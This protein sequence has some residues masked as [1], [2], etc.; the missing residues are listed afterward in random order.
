MIKKLN[1]MDAYPTA[2]LKYVIDSEWDILQALWTLMKKLTVPSN[3][4]IS[5]TIWN[6]PKEITKEPKHNI[7]DN[8]STTTWVSS[9]SDTITSG[10]TEEGDTDIIPISTP[11]IHLSQRPIALTITEPPKELPK[12]PRWTPP[13]KPIPKPGRW[14]L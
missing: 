9:D 3:I 10:E 5:E 12:D 1:S 14:K 13:P 6:T 2:Y 7:N 11:K 4:S 8:S